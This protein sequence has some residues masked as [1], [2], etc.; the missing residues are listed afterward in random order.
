M[1]VNLL[2]NLIIC[3]V[4]GHKMP[5]VSVGKKNPLVDGRQ[6]ET[7]MDIRMGMVRHYSKL[8]MVILPEFPLP[9]GRRADLIA[10]DKKGFFTIIEIKSSID[11]F[12][13]DTKWREYKEHCDKFLFA[14]HPKVPEE[15]FPNEEG[16]FVADRFGAHEVRESNEHRL[17]PARRK[18]LTLSFA[19]L[20]AKQL[21]RVSNY[22]LENGLDLPNDITQF[23]KNE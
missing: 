11:D 17:A 19:R 22:S 15:I 10:L 2:T 20:A 16:L 1:S 5:L 7:A 9:S 4:I 14:T 3:A 21:E 23:G 18:A 8:N 13:V 12:K 6:S